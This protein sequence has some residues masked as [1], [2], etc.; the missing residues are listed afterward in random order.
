M[1][2]S[3]SFI[4]WFP[5][6]CFFRF[7]DYCIFVVG[8][9]YLAILVR[10][11]SNTWCDCGPLPDWS[12]EVKPHSDDFWRSV[13]G[14]SFLS[15]TQRVCDL[16]VDIPVPPVTSQILVFSFWFLWSI[17][18]I[19]PFSSLHL[20]WNSSP[21]IIIIQ[22]FEGICPSHL[23]G[24]WGKTYTP[25]FII[26]LEKRWCGIQVNCS[27]KH[28]RSFLGIWLLNFS[29]EK[30][31]QCK[32]GTI[33]GIVRMTTFTPPALSSLSTSFTTVEQGILAR[34]TNP[35]SDDRWHGWTFL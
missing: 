18:S 23:Y 8:T 16:G 34:E 6:L 15:K 12:R 30:L 22:H 10:L 35:Y 5:C 25:E 14:G 4:I 1:N 3:G 27:F 2:R 26:D 33:H 31:I 11:W 19:T 24:F 28:I 29:G 32:C 13:L 20:I 7:W 17:E 21:L 9:L